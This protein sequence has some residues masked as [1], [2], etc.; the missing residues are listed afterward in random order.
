MCPSLFV[1]Q[2]L[3]HALSLDLFSRLKDSSYDFQVP[4]DK[5]RRNG[6]PRM[7]HL[8]MF[9]FSSSRSCGNETQ[10]FWSESKFENI[11]LLKTVPNTMALG[12]QRIAKSTHAGFERPSLKRPP[13]P[14]CGLS[15]WPQS[16]IIKM[17]VCPP[18]KKS[19][20]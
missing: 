16:Q 11:F 9:S 20:I 10:L 5:R 4:E 14:A 8:G 7:P 17:H 2:A 19:T 15:K 18:E 6:T 3:T 13:T 1:R 12:M